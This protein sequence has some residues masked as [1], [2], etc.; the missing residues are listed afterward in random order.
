MVVMGTVQVVLNTRKYGL[1][2]TV[3]TI[4]NGDE[5]RTNMT[6]WVNVTFLV[7]LSL[8]IYLLTI[9]LSETLLKMKKMEVENEY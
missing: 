8:I 2:Y 5:S 9:A 4:T 6:I 7:F 1:T 3:I